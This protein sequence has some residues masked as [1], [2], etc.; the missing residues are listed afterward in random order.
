MGLLVW[1]N[2]S[3]NCRIRS[4]VISGWSQSST[5]TASK[6]GWLDK[7]LPNPAFNDVAIPSD[8]SGLSMIVTGISANSGAIFSRLAPSTTA[9]G[10]FNCADRAVWVIRRMSVVPLM[11]NNCFGCPSKR[12]AAPAAKMMML[13]FKSLLRILAYDSTGAGCSTG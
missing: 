13:T 9:M 5:I 4:A 6:D 12:V 2:V 3:T 10:P 8:Q 1:V 7:R 11:V